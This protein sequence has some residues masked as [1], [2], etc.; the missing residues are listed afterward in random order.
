MEVFLDSFENS[1]SYVFLKND[2]LLSATDTSDS[3]YIVIQRTDHPDFEIRT[4]DK[5]MYSTYQ[6]DI[7]CNKVEEIEN[8]G[9]YEIVH[10][11]KDTNNDNSNVVYKNQIIGKVITIVDENILNSISLKTWSIAIENMNIN[12]I[13]D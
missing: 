1:E 3:S 10:I 9:T 12:S 8:I 7:S 5:I 11:N 13:I 6:G 4:N 2:N